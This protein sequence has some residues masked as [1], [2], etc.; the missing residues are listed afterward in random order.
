MAR[1]RRRVA[2][3]PR[4]PGVFLIDTWEEPYVTRQFAGQRTLAQLRRPPAARYLGTTTVM[5]FDLSP[6]QHA[7]DRPTSELID[8]YKGSRSVEPV[9]L[10]LPDFD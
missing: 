8:D 5:L 4:H 3:R 2:V 7:G 6:T 1:S 9:P 10:E